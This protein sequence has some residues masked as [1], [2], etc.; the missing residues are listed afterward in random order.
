M[1]TA[2]FKLFGVS[3]YSQ[4]A[5][6]QSKK[7]E[8]SSH[9]KFEEETWRERMHADKVTG[10]VFIPPMALK[11]CLSECAKFISMSVPGKGKATFTKHFEAGLLCTEPLSLGILAAD[12]K[13]ERLYVPAD[14]RRGGGKRVWKNFPYIPPGWTAD[15]SVFIMDDTITDSVFET[16]L[17]RAGQ[18]IGLGRFRPRNNG[19]YGRFE[20]RGLKFT[21][22][23]LASL[24]GVAKT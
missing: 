24:T 23:N 5:I 10:I 1:K 16:H 13:C 17:R 12:V 14:G 9:D 11:N 3:P 18:F 15:A 19:H 8:L 21:D 2:T 7:E 6:I 22:E 20:V 4:G